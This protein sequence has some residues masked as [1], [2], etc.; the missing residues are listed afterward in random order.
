MKKLMLLFSVLLL[1]CSMTC[2]DERYVGELLIKNESNEPIYYYKEFSTTDVTLDDI[3]KSRLD[4]QMLS[5]GEKQKWLLY[6]D[7]FANDSK[8]YVYFFK[9]SI[10]DQYSWE[11]IKENNVYSKRYIYTLSELKATKWSIIFTDN[12]IN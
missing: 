3:S 4:N 11:E 8:I 5:V 1:F 9:K 7:S 12:D 10:L 6:E 2:D